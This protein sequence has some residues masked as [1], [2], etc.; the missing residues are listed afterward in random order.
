VLHPISPTCPREHLVH[1]LRVRWVLCSPSTLCTPYSQRLG[2]FA[3]SPHPGVR[4]FPTLR[5]LCPI[6]LLS[7]SSGFRMGL[8]T[9]TLHSPSHSLRSLPCS[10]VGLKQDAVGGVLS[11][12][13]SAL[14]G[15]PVV[16]QG[17]TGLPV[18]PSAKRD[19]YFALAFLPAVHGWFSLTGRHHK[20]GMSGCLF[21][22]RLGTLRVDSPWHLLAK[23]CFLDTCFL[24]TAPFRSMLLTWSS[25]RQRLTPRAHGVPVYPKVLPHSYFALSRR[26]ISI[27]NV[28]ST[29]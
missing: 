20:Q 18:S 17:K 4:G 28:S 15:S 8:P 26:T 9:P 24:L 1:S 16:A 21:P 3:V 6:R 11:M 27:N 25:G 12:A 29:R 22:V 19:G 23:H 10:L 2:A 13:S 7:R 5:L 14:C